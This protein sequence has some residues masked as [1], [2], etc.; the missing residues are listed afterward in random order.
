MAVITATAFTRTN[1][2][3]R[4]LLKHIEMGILDFTDLFSGFPSAP[5]QA[6]CQAQEQ[7]G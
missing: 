2:F 3:I 5:Q 6:D 1:F 4:S 7:T